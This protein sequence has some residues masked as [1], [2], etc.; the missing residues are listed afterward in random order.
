M[1]HGP[2]GLLYSELWTWSYSDT[3][4]KSTLITGSMLNM[5]MTTLVLFKELLN[6][7]KPLRLM[8]CLVINLE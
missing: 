3:S 8:L 1:S 2:L 4:N 6:F 5:E 7:L